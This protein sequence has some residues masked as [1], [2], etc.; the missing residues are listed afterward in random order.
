MKNNV[1]ERL[2]FGAVAFVIVEVFLL[3]NYGGYFESSFLGAGCL[4]LLV[5]CVKKD[6]FSIDLS[7]GL[8]CVFSLWYLGCSLKNGF[9]LEYFAKGMV[10]LCML[11]LWLASERCCGKSREWIIDVITEISVWIALIA[12]IHCIVVSVN[13]GYLGRLTF[14]F[15]Y[16]NA[17]GIYFAV[18]YHF[19]VSSGVPFVRRC[20][21]VF[22]V[23]L[24]MTQSV[25]AVGIFLVYMGYNLVSQRKFG[26]LCLMVG[27]VAVLGIVFSV[28]IAESVGTFVERILQMRDG[29]ACL[30]ENPGFGIGAGWWEYAKNYYQTGFYEANVIHSSFV[31]VG[32]DSGILGLILFCV[33]CFLELKKLRKNKRYF[34]VAAMILFHSLFDFTLSFG[35]IS[36]ILILSLGG[37]CP[38][39]AFEISCLKKRLCSFAVL[40]VCALTVCG[41][42]EV[43][44]FK[45]NLQK[46]KDTEKLIRQHS[47]SFC[48]SHSV[49]ANQSLSGVLYNEKIYDN[50]LLSV[51]YKYM[52]TAMVLFNSLFE[53]DGNEYLT[54]NY[55]LQPYNKVLRSYV[56]D[57][58][59]SAA[60]GVETAM[61]KMSFW[62]KI[63]YKFKGENL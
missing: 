61:E 55:G 32:V 39:K 47:E 14:P 12:I 63:L 8:F 57:E 33:V 50:G 59:A 46:E 62:G 34:T 44:V 60:N 5:V 49:A 48:I 41:L 42:I 16:S 51:K 56:V 52:P 43:A 24:V 58:A 36:L 6:S 37:D 53:A 35:A 1:K 4:A 10:P 40:I 27:I 31:A 9:V 26:I 23:A 29:M 22:L 54:A 38:E 19:S 20:R 15:D 11:I 25:G 30:F 18:C 13:G 28:R 21:F 17:C 3:L 2:R 7:K 45:G